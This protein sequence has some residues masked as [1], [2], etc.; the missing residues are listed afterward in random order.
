MRK[1]EFSKV[2]YKI[3]NKILNNLIIQQVDNVQ[4]KSIVIFSVT[5]FRQN[6]MPITYKN[7]K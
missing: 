5:S 6:G 4:V 7:K 2:L 3:L 1:N